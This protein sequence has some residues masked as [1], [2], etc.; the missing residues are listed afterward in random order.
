MRRGSKWPITIKEASIPTSWELPEDFFAVK[1]FRFRNNNGDEQTATWKAG[2]NTTVAIAEDTVF[3]VRFAI[4]EHRRLNASGPF[5]LESSLEGGSWIRLGDSFALKWG[6]SLFFDSGDDTTQQISTGTFVGRNAGMERSGA[7]RTF[8]E[9]AYFRGS[10][11]TE[12]E[13]ACYVE[14]GTTLDQDRI[15]LRIVESQTGKPLKH[16]VFPYLT[17]TGGAPGGGKGDPPVFE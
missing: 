14:D 16:F 11:W 3:R 17:V 5:E 15:W 7:A 2:K 8:G 1:A 9:T 13:L 6:F 12:C 4:Q 10:D